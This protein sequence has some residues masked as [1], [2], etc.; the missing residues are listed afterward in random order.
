MVGK[1]AA[2]VFSAGLALMVAIVWNLAAGMPSHQQQRATG[3]KLFTAGNYR[4]AYEWLRKLA[5]DPT[6]DPLRVGDD[7]DLGVASL[8]KLG[9]IDEADDFREAVVAA[10]AKNWRLLEAAARSYEKTEHFGFIVAGKFDRGNKR[11]GG[12]CVHH[13]ARPRAGASAFAASSGTS[14]EVRGQKRRGA[15][16]IHFASALL[17]GGGFYEPWRLQYLTD[18]SKLPDYDEGYFGYRGGAVGAPVDEQGNPV[19]HH[20]PKTYAAAATDGERWRWLLDEAVEFDPSRA[21]EVDVGFA[22]F[23]AVQLGVQTMAYYG[24]GVGRNGDQG[25]EENRHLRPA[26]PERRRNHRPAGH[27]HQALQAA[28]RVQ[29]DQ[30]LRARRRPRQE[31]LRANRPATRSRQIYEDRRQYV[32]AADAWKRAIDEY[33]AGQRQLSASSGSTRSSATGAASSTAR[34]SPPARTPSSISA[35]AT[36]TRSRSRPTRSR[37]PSCSTT[38]RLT[39]RATRASS[40]GTRSTSATSATA[41]SS[42]TSSSTSATRSPPGTWT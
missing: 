15:F 10:H 11:G 32:K 38:S 22:N 4:D 28:R 13:A 5:L 27:R 9:R 23:L 7:L 29:L 12:R 17:N 14:H 36:A 2:C 18:L 8:Q 19:Y 20:L 34:S 21:N 3:T 37:S 31:P 33:G 35:S 40:T 1:K 25:E 42:R 6:D 30:D 26:H 16:Y 41:W 24:F 39:S